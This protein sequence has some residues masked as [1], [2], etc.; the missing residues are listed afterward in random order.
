MALT[1]EEVKELKQ[2]SNGLWKD[3][4]KDNVVYSQKKYLNELNKSV[5]K[6]DSKINNN[7][8][9]QNNY[10]QNYYGSNNVQIM[11]NNNNVG[12]VGSLF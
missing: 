7:N 9:T 5:K 8:N 10:Y 2:W 11:G 4:N 1:Q 3:I 12:S 6:C